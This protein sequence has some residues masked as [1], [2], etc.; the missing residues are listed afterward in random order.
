MN[1]SIVG[2]V[3]TSCGAVRLGDLSRGLRIEGEYQSCWELCRE[4]L[5][6]DKRQNKDGGRHFEA[7]T[8]EK[9][10]YRSRPGVYHF[11]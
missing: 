9:A 6:D 3:F 8:K 11:E 7:D 5:Q 4:G 2:R 1:A 10:F